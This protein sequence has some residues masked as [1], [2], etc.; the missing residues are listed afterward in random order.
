MFRSR[1]IRALAVLALVVAQP[2]LG[3]PLH[4]LGQTEATHVQATAGEHD[5]CQQPTDGGKTHSNAPMPPCGSCPVSMPGGCPDMAGCGAISLAP[6]APVQDA[7][8]I[9]VALELAPAISAPA[10]HD[11]IP[12]PPPPRA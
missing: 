10:A 1:L 6:S 7:P 2:A 4:T 11:F 3:L 5:H 12:D 9:D 8:A